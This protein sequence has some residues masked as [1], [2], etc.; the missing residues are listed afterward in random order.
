M[1]HV[2]SC[3]PKELPDYLADN[4]V[5]FGRW[6]SKD[7]VLGTQHIWSIPLR[8]VYY[9][10]D[11][12]TGLI[13]SIGKS[14]REAEYG[15][16]VYFERKRAKAEASSQLAE[17]LRTILSNFLAECRVKYRILSEDEKA[18]IIESVISD[19]LGRVRY[20]T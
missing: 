15:A 20:R 11:P 3:P 5:A 9:V 18:D 16:N 19:F 12:E 4:V 14:Q 13:I 6:Q 7:Q 17:L 10:I 8:I 2:L 1:V